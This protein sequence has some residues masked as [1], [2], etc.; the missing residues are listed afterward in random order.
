[1]TILKAANSLLSVIGVTLLFNH[2]GL[3]VLMERLNNHLNLDVPLDVR[4]GAWEVLTKKRLWM[5]VCMCVC[6]CIYVYGKRRRV[7]SAH[8]EESVD[9]GVY[10][11]MYVCMHV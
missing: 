11:C 6:M 3:S 10:V 7:R 8:K 9:G 5:E 2:Y 4:V 1:M